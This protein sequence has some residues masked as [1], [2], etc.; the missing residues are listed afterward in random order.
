MTE[1]QILQELGL[2]VYEAKIYLALVA[3]GAQ[4]SK[5]IAFRTNIPKN[6]IYD[7]IASLERKEFVEVIL[8]N[9]QKFKAVNPDLTL[10]EKI[11]SL[12]NLRK[13]LSEAFKKQSLGKE[14]NILILRG[15]ENAV[16]RRIRDLSHTKKEYCAFVGKEVTTP[17]LEMLSRELKNAVNRGV[18]IRLL[19]NICN[20][21]E[22]EKA[23]RAID[24]GAETKNFPLEGFSMSVCDSKIVWIEF[25]DKRF[26]RVN[27]KIENEHFAKAVHDYFEKIWKDAKEFTPKA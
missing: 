11:S 22:L 20:K 2:T 1:L 26:E 24:L 19:R 27:I 13:K 7:S 5:E 18:K 16:R 17:N 23:Q 15:Y 12:E 9:P 8:G 3:Y 6:R 4:N 21:E 14:E 25:P 10:K